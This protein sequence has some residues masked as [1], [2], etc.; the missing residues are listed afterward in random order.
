MANENSELQIDILNGQTRYRCPDCGRWTYAGP[1]AEIK[2]STRCDLSHLRAPRESA[3]KTAPVSRE[4]REE[5]VRRL[6]DQ[7]T[8]LESGESR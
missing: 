8:R 2:H 7:G 4:T 6:A 1:K 5:Y 3:A